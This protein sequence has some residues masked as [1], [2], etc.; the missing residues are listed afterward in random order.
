MNNGQVNLQTYAA[1]NIKYLR[2]RMLPEISFCYFHRLTKWSLLSFS[3]VYL[4]GCSQH[5]AV[6]ES[7]ALVKEDGSEKEFTSITVQPCVDRTEYDGTVDIGNMGTE[8]LREKVRESGLLV[9]SDSAEILL[10][11][12]IE[13]FIEGSAFKRWI[14]PGW[15]ST[16]GAVSVMLVRKDG[17]KVLANF[18]SQA[19]VEAGGFYTLGAEEYILDSAFD[20]IVKQLREWLDKSANNAQ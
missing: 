15:G 1:I 16:Q 9:I 6:G 20:E 17:Y 2:P 7:V 10:T 19:S 5:M 14:M 12:D 4:H 8:K 3:I 13:R 11:C 18:K